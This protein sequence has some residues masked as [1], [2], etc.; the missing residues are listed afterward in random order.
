MTLYLLDTNHLSAAL[1]NDAN[2]RRQLCDLRLRGD[3][4]GTCVPALC[5][6]QAG[7]VLSARREY[8]QQ[9]LRALL[10]QIRIWP[11][12][13]ATSIGYGE[14][15]HEL[16]RKGRALSQVD[17]MLAALA[18]QLNATLLSTD[19]DFDAIADIRRESWLR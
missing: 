3:R 16:R 19:R 12:D 7:I 18:R 11:L 14:L 5:E 1:N 10:R 13:P 17:I 15:Y 2:V 9:I 6:L 8:N 4:I